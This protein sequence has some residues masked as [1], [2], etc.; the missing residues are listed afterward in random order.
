MESLQRT[1]LT[2]DWKLFMR[3]QRNCHPHP[4]AGEA[5]GHL[6]VNQ[7]DQLGSHTSTQFQL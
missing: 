3:K 1:F 6:W 4:R 2:S 5:W 7:T